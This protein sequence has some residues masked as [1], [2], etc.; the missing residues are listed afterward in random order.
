MPRPVRTPPSFCSRRIRVLANRCRDDKP[1]N[2]QRPNRRCND[3]MGIGCG[4]NNLNNIYPHG[5]YLVFR[6]LTFF[7][8]LTP[9]FQ[10]EPTFLELSNN[11]I[12]QLHQGLL[13]QDQQHHST[14]SQFYFTPNEP[15]P[16]ASTLSCPAF[17]SLAR[18]ISMRY[19]AGCLHPKSK[20]R[21][22]GDFRSNQ[23]LQL[24]VQH[25]KPDLRV[26]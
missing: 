24:E 26:L 12:R 14:L 9:F 23:Q 5:G 17:F 13:V 16:S 4:L 6:N 18:I 19:H 22:V 7:F 3:F 1:K 10:T 25:P 2:F 21:S 11:T 8:S 15:R 20:L